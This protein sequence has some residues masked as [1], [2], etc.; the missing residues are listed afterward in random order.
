MFA[1]P[2]K[3]VTIYLV[4]GFVGRSYARAFTQ[5][6][7]I[8]NPF[9]ATGIYSLDPDIFDY[10]DFNASEV[11]NR[12]EAQSASTTTNNHPPV[13][14]LNNHPPSQSYHSSRKNE[15]EF[16]KIEQT[17][18]TPTTHQGTFSE[19]IFISPGDLKGYPKA[20]HQNPTRKR[21]SLGKS[22]FLCFYFNL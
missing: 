15:R 3:N 11:T 1:N 19:E 20:T 7:N 4:D 5:F 16:R 22:R 18:T 14:P 6:N 9:R 17:K 13:Q 8:V 12:L 10:S 21:R 2:G